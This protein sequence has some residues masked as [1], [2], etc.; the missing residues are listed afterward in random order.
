MRARV[1]RSGPGGRESRPASATGRPQPENSPAATAPAGSILLG[2]LSRL[3]KNWQE[4]LII[5]KPETV[6]KWHRQCFKLCWRWKSKALVGSPKID[7]EIRELIKRISLEIIREW[8]LYSQDGIFGMDCGGFNKIACD[9]GIG[10][11]QTAGGKPSTGNHC[12]I[13]PVAR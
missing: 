11:S 3:W 9:Y 13:W 7:R 5:V 8:A 10:V 2:I 6:I 12:P 1:N 4:V